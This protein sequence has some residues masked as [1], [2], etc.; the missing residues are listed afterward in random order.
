MKQLQIK[1]LKKAYKSSLKNTKKQIVSTDK[2][3]GL[4]LFVEHLKYL[5]DLYTLKTTIDFS[6][7]T[8]IS[9][10]TAIAEFDAYKKTADDSQKCFHW[11]NFC[12]LLKQNMKE[13]LLL[14]DSI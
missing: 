6:N 4:N 12:E 14:N 3:I 5:R 2:N 8:F 10:I 1:Q 11:Q 9:L 13:W 7:T